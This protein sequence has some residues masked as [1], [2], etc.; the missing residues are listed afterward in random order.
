[1]TSFGRNITGK[2]V[3]E[4]FADPLEG[5]TSSSHLLILQ[6]SLTL[7]PVLI[8][9]PSFSSIGGETA[10]SLAYGNSAQI[11]LAGRTKSRALPVI[12]KIHE[13]NSKIVTKFV[14]VN[15]ASQTSVRKA[16]EEINGSVNR[17]DYLINNAGIIAI[18][19]F[20]TTEDGIE[21]QFGSNHIGH[22]LLTNLVMGKILAAGK[23][24]RIINVS[25]TGFELG[26]FRFDDWNFKVHQVFLRSTVF[27]NMHLQEGK[28]YG[29]WQAYA[30]SK[31]G[32]VLFSAALAERLKSR[33]SSL[34]LCSLALFRPV[35]L[36]HISLRIP[37]RML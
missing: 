13:L 15:L 7:Q 3:V 22:F 16:A 4:A 24:A 9:G 27:F 14:H 35:I 2:E 30:Q 10:I 36:P 31:T 8:T 21:S 28:E 6:P 25:S 12:H 19:T 33:E 17:I 32:N 26:G 20:E 11:L 1:M 34:S 5:K 18:P 29:P 37:G 23:G